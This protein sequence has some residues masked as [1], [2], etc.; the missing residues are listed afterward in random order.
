MKIVLLFLAVL[1]LQS[2]PFA[3]SYSFQPTDEYIG[4]ADLEAYNIFQVNLVNTSND[5][6]YLNWRL[7]EN[8]LPETWEISLCDNVA[9]Y[10]GLP[11]MAEMDPFAAGDSAFIKLDINP[12][13][14]EGS[15]LLRFR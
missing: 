10:G 4:E 9:C 1:C 13:I 2:S 3:Q 7:V 5:S 15:G 11:T 12:G 14:Q 8:T 6:L